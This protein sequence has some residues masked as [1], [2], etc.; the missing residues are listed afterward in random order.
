MEVMSL[1]SSVTSNS[2]IFELAYFYYKEVR[3]TYP[4]MLQ[5][6]LREQLSRGFAHDRNEPAGQSGGNLEA[7]EDRS[8]RLSGTPLDFQLGNHW[9]P[10]ESA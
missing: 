9:T 8:D 2:E 5:R 1:M 10:E 7:K 3:I 4:H 6:P